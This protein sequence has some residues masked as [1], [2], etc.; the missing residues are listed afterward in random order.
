VRH[1]FSSVSSNNGSA[2]HALPHRQLR[3]SSPSLAGVDAMTTY[4]NLPMH[5]LA[6]VAA[7]PPLVHSSQRGSYFEAP[8]R[9][10]TAADRTQR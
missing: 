5:A 1:R 2:A 9:T 7:A 8:S 6:A 3:R 10:L 4:Q